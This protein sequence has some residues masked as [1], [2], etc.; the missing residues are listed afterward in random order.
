[1]GLSRSRRNA[2]FLLEHLKELSGRPAIRLTGQKG[3]TAELIALAMCH[4]NCRNAA[5]DDECW[6][7]LRNGFFV[8][9]DDICDLLPPVAESSRSTT[10][11][12]DADEDGT[13]RATRPDLIYVSSIP[14]KGLVFRFAEVKYRRHLRTARSPEALQRIRQQVE[15]LRRRWNDW[16]AGDEACPL[17]RAVR[18]AKLARVLRFYADKAKRHATDDDGLTGSAFQHLSTEI[19]RLVEKGGGYGSSEKFY[20]TS[21]TRKRG[22]ECENA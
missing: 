22:K 10:D 3:P 14:R 12:A 1:M 6:T 7:S 13:Q 2:E 17:F 21:P 9:V 8:P 5:L 18:R 11:D 4:A 19:D 20:N 16:Y 15:S